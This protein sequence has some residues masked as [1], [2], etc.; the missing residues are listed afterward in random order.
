M[1]NRMLLEP[2]SW[3]LLTETVRRAPG[4]LR[5]YEM[6]P[7]GG[8][9]DCLTLITT[10]GD[11]V[12]HLNRAGRFTPEA[13]LRERSVGPVLHDPWDIWE[14]AEERADLANIVDGICRRIGLSVPE[15]L[16][17]SPPH[18]LV[19]R[20][21]TEILSWGVCRR[22]QWRCDSGFLDSS[23][24]EGSSVRKELFTRFPDAGT[25]LQIREA[26]DLLENPAYRF[27]FILR[28]KEPV[29]CFETTGTVWNLKGKSIDIPKAYSGP[30]RLWPLIT[31]IAGDLLP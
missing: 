15:K 7:G 24:F 11:T 4:R 16:P 2:L 10:E 27:W 1:S 9:Y 5:F 6:H 22:N 19:Y 12:A 23:G 29:L 31:E 8:Q 28:D 21:I 17:P 3:R 14:A 18:V 26:G 13:T 25:R 30:R 20:L